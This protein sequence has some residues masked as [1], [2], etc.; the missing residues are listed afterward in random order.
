MLV[1]ISGP[2][3]VE[4]WTDA[5]PAQLCLDSVQICGKLCLRPNRLH[6]PR[7]GTLS[8]HHRG[9]DRSAPTAG[10]LQAKLACG[11]ARRRRWWGNQSSGTRGMHRTANAFPTTTSGPPPNRRHPRGAL[12]RRARP[13]QPLQP[14]RD[15]APLRRVRCLALRA[16]ARLGMRRCRRGRVVRSRP[17]HILDTTGPPQPPTLAP[18]HDGGWRGTSCSSFRMCHCLFFPLL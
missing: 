7:S 16:A 10:R 13:Q 14:R 11:R 6:G 18:P 2:N 12:G 1:D 8:K 17:A 15:E 3:L 4:L 9:L 5:A